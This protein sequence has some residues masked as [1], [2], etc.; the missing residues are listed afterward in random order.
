M[1]NTKLYIEKKKRNKTQT[2]GSNEKSKNKYT[3]FTKRSF[4]KS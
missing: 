4:G 3:T 2:D 1:T